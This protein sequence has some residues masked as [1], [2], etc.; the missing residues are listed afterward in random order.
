MLTGGCLC[1]S[2]RFEISEPLADAGSCHCSMC[3]RAHGAAF[4]TFAAVKP[5]SFKWVSGEDDVGIYQSSEEGYRAFCR[6]CG[7]PLGA[8]QKGELTWVTLGT[9]EGDPGVRPQ[10]HIFVASKAPWF[11]I[12]DDLPQFDEYPPSMQQE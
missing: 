7:S 5:G 6:K 1:G 2:V 3:R 4:A 11:E 9:I 12:N 10:A 8:M